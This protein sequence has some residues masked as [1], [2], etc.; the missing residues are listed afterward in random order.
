MR[1]RAR[2]VTG[3]AAA[4]WGG[5]W[6]TLAGRIRLGLLLVS[7][8][9]LGITAIAVV[10]VARLHESAQEL[11]GHAKRAHAI[12]QMER[13]VIDGLVGTKGARGRVDLAAE[14][15]AE[16]SEEFAAVA[17]D[18]GRLRSA[19]LAERGCAA[20]AAMSKRWLPTGAEFRPQC[21]EGAAEQSYLARLRSLELE[22]MDAIVT[23]GG[24]LGGLADSSIRNVVTLTLA[25]I[26]LMFF[27]VWRFPGRLHMPL[28]RL[29][30]VMHTAQGGRTDVVAPLVGLSEMDDIARTLNSMMA[31]FREF[32][33]RKRSRILLDRI[34]LGLLLD[35]LPDAA[36]LVD[37]NLVVDSANGVMRRLL[38]MG[39]GCV[40][41]RLTE[42]LD[43]GGTALERAAATVIDG[44]E[45]G[46]SDTQVVA[47][48]ER[49]RGT[50]HLVPITGGRGQVE[51]LLIELKI[52]R[53]PMG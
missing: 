14:R 32:D 35:R 53:N 38:G 50:A 22:E 39:D 12:A 6:G 20:L 21:S 25:G 23:G 2:I 10:Y 9:F 46:E 44:R 28:R 37:R 52:H 29:S 4:V 30:A 15:L 1:G 31:S 3:W 48:K 5:L 27:L 26:M 45:E 16:V 13:A 17:A 49:I 11:H 42:F 8:A 33:Q 40:G 51:A 18:V 47:G 34:K 7:G 41:R 19:V 36:V 24:A 43:G